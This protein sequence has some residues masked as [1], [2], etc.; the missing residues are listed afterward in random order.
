[1]KE[2]AEP[3]D[4]L[5]RIP[6]FAE[7]ADEQLRW[8]GEAGERR[9][10]SHGEALF[11]AGQ[12]GTHFYVLLV[13]DLVISAELGGREQELT[14]HS[15]HSGAVTSEPGKP[16]TAH[17]ITGE[18]AMLTDTPYLANAT[19]DGPV[20]VLAFPKPVFTEMLTRCPSVPRRLLPALAWRAVAT[21]DQVRSLASSAALNV[22]ASSLAHELNNPVTVVDR[23]A[24]ELTGFVELLAETAWSWSSAAS[25]AEFGVVTDMMRA[26]LAKG[27]PADD[28]GATGSPLDDSLAQVAEEDALANWARKSGAGHAD[29]LATVMIERGLRLADLRDH[30]RDLGPDVRPAVL[31]HL[32][33]VLEMHSMAAELAAA[34]S[35]VTGLVA[36]TR[37]YSAWERGPR[38]SFSIVECVEN[39]LGQLRTRLGSVRVIRSY[40]PGLPA[41]S[42]YPTEMNRVLTNLVDNAVDAM[43]GL[44]TLV[45]SV[46]RE[47]TFLTVEVTDSGRGIPAEALPHIFE[48]FSTT[49]DAGKGSGLGL[50]LAHQIVTQRHHGTIS[51]HSVPGETHFAVRLPVD[52]DHRMERDP[53]MG[54]YDIATLHPVFRRQMEALDALDLDALMKNY[55]DD[56]VLLRYEGVSTGIKEVRETFTGYLSVKPKLLDLQEYVETADTIF[57]R[58]IMSLNGE[59]EHAFGTLVVR[60]GK[61]WRQTAGFGS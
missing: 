49:K 23:V 38:H 24:R 4:A 44:G 39:A 54:T 42:G 18:M 47:N 37:D 22:L 61:I 36:A 13:G 53:T 31:D 19:A 48:P 21:H 57:Y 60:D 3:V 5:R 14:R 51:A 56:A 45:V 26:F 11:R 16:S 29:L 34:S 27:V 7:E 40:Q 6:L 30:T 9:R 50:H 12:P 2:G 59:P 20:V 58:A 33:A 35:R 41:L 32:T 52:S 1:M 28:L 25:P 8:L 46:R 17:R 10:L 15:A 55:T 43:R